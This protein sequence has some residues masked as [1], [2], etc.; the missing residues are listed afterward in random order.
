MRRTIVLGSGLL[1]CCVLGACSLTSQEGGI[2]SVAMQG[3]GEGGYWVH[4]HFRNEGRR[5]GP[6][7]TVEEARRVAGQHNATHHFGT[8]T[9][10][11]SS[12]ADGLGGWHR[13][14]PGAPTPWHFLGKPRDLP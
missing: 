9:A 2:A 8:R 11:V 1:A 5:A 14:D 4:D 12:R 3:E 6:F 10:Y 7:D 13:L